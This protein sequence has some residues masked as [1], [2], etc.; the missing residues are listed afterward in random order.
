M[1]T[2]CESV[3][4]VLQQTNPIGEEE[5]AVVMG[6][7]GSLC[8]KKVQEVVVPIGCAHLAISPSVGLSTCVCPDSSPCNRS[9]APPATAVHLQHGSRKQEGTRQKGRCHQRIGN[10]LTPNPSSNFFSAPEC[11]AAAEQLCR[12]CD[13]QRGKVSGNSTR[14]VV[15]KSHPHRTSSL[16]F[17][18]ANSYKTKGM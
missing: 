18:L 1:S 11:S 4:N 10:E 9:H 14:E 2:P 16:V 8:C 15:G 7:W 13:L 6:D 17:K 5:E 3:G 12:A